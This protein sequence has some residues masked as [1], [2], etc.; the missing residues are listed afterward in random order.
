M[1]EDAAETFRLLREWRNEIAKNDGIPPY[2]IC[3]NRLLA[4]IANAKP[5]TLEG[6]GK[7]PGFGEGK[8]KRYGQEILELLRKLEPSPMKEE[9]CEQ[10]QV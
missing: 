4:Q 1:Q 7:L 8:L 5:D 2:V 3:N 6:L 9:A 10:L